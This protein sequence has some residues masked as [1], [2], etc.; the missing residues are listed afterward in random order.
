MN[1]IAYAAKAFGY[2]PE[3]FLFELLNRYPE[4]VLKPRRRRK[5]ALDCLTDLAIEWMC[6][7]GSLGIDEN[8]N[9]FLK[10]KS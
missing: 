3:A 7:T 5:F 9:P 6:Y 1:K 10:A 2:L 4:V 8:G